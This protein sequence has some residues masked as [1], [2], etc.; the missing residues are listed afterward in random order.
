[1]DLTS[2]LRSLVGV[3]FAACAVFLAG[4]FYSGSRSAPVL[5]DLK[6]RIDVADKEARATKKKQEED[7]V[8][9]ANEIRG[10][11][12]RVNLEHDRVLQRQSGLQNRALA[13]CAKRVDGAAANLADL[14]EVERRFRLNENQILMWQHW[15]ITHKF[16]IAD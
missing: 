11:I 5:A 1:M 6:A 3:L 9:I 4:Y 8:K 14:A 2:K 7:N 15:A 13:E 12:D 16:P 10:S